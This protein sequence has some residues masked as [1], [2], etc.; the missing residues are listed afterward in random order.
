MPFKPNW[1]DPNPQL[2]ELCTAIR[3]KSILRRSNACGALK[4]LAS[5]PIN[6][7]AL[8]RTSGVLYSLTY[9]ISKRPERHDFDACTDTLIR[10][11]T[12]IMHLSI[13]VENRQMIFNQ[14][15]LV[16][17]L[18]HVISYDKME[19]RVNCCTALTYLAKTP[20]NRE[21]M[22]KVPYLVDVLASI[23]NNDMEFEINTD[24]LSVSSDEFS[25]NEGNKSAKEREKSSRYE[26]CDDDSMY[27]SGD[28]T[29]VSSESSHVNSN[30]APNRNE[31]SAK[32]LSK[33]K[34]AVL[35]EKLD[36]YL[37]SSRLA[38][39]AVLTHLL[40]HCPNAVSS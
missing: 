29:I 11:T 26:D 21:R 12:A 34:N 6:R 30:N 39:C 27:N 2:Q 15:R 38:A 8:A 20:E 35:Q 23:V 22:T 14:P 33:R 19:A 40:K 32:K 24:L 16:K 28:S 25:V 36:H 17:S 9:A 10:A 18:L 3:G 5:K 37:A 4:V 7:V 31:S 13:P 1:K